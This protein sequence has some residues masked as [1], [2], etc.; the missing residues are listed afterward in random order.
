MSTLYRTAYRVEMKTT[1]VW[2]EQKTAQNW[3]KSL[4]Q[5]NRSYRSGWPREPPSV[6]SLRH[7]F[8]HQ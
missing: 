7:F 8:Q 4:T 2:Y 1:P 6:G 5:S 3:N